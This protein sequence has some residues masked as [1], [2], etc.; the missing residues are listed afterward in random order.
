MSRSGSMTRPTP[1]SVSATRKLELPSSGAGI[2]STVYMALAAD[3]NGGQENPDRDERDHDRAAIENGLR[4]Q[5][6]GRMQPEVDQQVAKSVRE[7][8]ERPCDQPE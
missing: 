7:L 8:E 2:A 5:A 4:G 6:L 3:W 1:R